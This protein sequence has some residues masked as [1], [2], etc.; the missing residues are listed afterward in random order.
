VLLLK[1]YEKSEEDRNSYLDKNLD[2]G[3]LFLIASKKRFLWF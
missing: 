3:E 1:L 2:H